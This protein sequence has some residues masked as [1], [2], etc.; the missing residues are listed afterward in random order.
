MR[1]IAE[2]RLEL[3]IRP[4]GVR[5]RKFEVEVM[6]SR[7]YFRSLG[8][9]SATTSPL[10]SLSTERFYLDACM[11]HYIKVSENNKKKYF[12][13]YTD[14]MK[15]HLPILNTHAEVIDL[16]KATNAEIQDAIKRKLIQLKEPFI[17]ITKKLV[18]RSLMQKNHLTFTELY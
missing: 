4:T 9:L 18:Q 5:R 14:G 12:E 3:N 10:V 11:E 1:S 15:S 7:K 13:H 16:S 17:L 2:A 6:Q 8:T